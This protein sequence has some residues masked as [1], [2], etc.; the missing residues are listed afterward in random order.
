MWISAIRDHNLRKKGI[1]V[2]RGGPLKIVDNPIYR[3]DKKMLIRAYLD[4]LLWVMGYVKKLISILPG[5]IV[6]TADHGDSFGERLKKFPI[7]IYGHPPF[8]HFEQLIKVPWLE[9]EGKGNKVAI[10]KELARLQ[11]EISKN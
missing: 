9:V 4:N 3:I 6:V 8:L 5:K 2:L 1:K 7:E 10:L 11:K